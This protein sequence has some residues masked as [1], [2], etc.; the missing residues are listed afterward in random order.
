MHFGVEEVGHKKIILDSKKKI[1]N[2]IESLRDAASKNEIGG[3]M[4]APNSRLRPNAMG[5]IIDR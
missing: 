1:L 4:I 5:L 2:L 3:K